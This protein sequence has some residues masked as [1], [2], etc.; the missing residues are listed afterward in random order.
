MKRLLALLRPQPRI[1]SKPSTHSSRIFKIIQ[2][3]HLVHLLYWFK[4]W[5]IMYTRFV[6]SNPVLNKE[7]LTSHAV[8]PTPPF[9]SIRRCGPYYHTEYTM[10]EG[11]YVFFLAF[12]PCPFPT[13]RQTKGTSY[14][15]FGVLTLRSWQYHILTQTSINTC[16]PEFEHGPSKRCPSLC[17]P[18]L[19]QRL[20]VFTNRTT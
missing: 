14:I 8:I 6:S 18:S 4:L 16:G 5:Y 11:K 3:N 9:S 19:M 20:W 13:D 2:T 17:V 7:H 12:C 10:G 15:M 1:T